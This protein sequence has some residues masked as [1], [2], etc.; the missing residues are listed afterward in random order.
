MTSTQTL[1]RHD[2][3]PMESDESTSSWVDRHARALVWL[4]ND[5]ARQTPD[6]AGPKP[7]ESSEKSGQDMWYTRI[8]PVWR[9]HQA[10]L[11]STPL[12]KKWPKWGIRSGGAH[13]ALPMLERPIGGNESLSSAGWPTPE[14]GVYGTADVPRLLARRERVKAEKKN[15]N[16]FGLT[17]GQK[18]AV[19]NWP[20]PRAYS[21]QD[22]HLPGLTTLDIRVRGLYP[23]ADRYWPSL[24]AT[25]GSSSGPNQRGSKGDLMLPSAV[26]L[27]PTPAAADS[28]GGKIRKG[29]GPTGQMPDGSKATVS[30]NQAVSQLWPT[31]TVN[32]AGN[33]TAPPSQDARHSPGLANVAQWA[34]PRASPNENR[35]TKRTP[36]QEDGRRGEYLAVQVQGPTKGQLS[37]RWV[38]ILQGLPPDYLEISLSDTPTG[39]RAPAPSSIRTS[40]PEPRRKKRSESPNSQVLATALSPRKSGP[41]SAP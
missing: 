11:F 37:S 25:D 18:I 28:T 30:L 33:A 9:V 36:A 24:R 22:S 12:Q 20:T 38:T 6:S 41:S 7:L 35:T 34:T 2:S 27:W 40:P 3:P 16:G 5:L 26:Q 19:M 4:V 32:D 14:A 13:G 21:F 10:V 1:A 17:L 31:P 15:G 29:M 8:R 23:D 39:R